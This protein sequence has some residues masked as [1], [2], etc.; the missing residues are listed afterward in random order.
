MLNANWRSNSSDKGMLLVQRIGFNVSDGPEGTQ[1][2]VFSD[3]V[4]LQ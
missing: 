4:T 1:R 3:T 2:N